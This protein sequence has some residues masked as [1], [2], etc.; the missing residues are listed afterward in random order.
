[1]TR[2]ALVDLDAIRSNLAV[3]STATAATP[4]M[5][6][7]KANAY[8]HGAVPVARAVVEA[9]AAWLGTAD[10]AE[11]LELRAAGVTAPILAWLH[12]PD[13]DFAPAIEGGVD[14]G[15]SYPR[16]LERVAAASWRSCSWRSSTPVWAVTERIPAR[17]LELVEAAAAHQRAGRL[18][19]RGVWSHLANAGPDADAGRQIATFTEAL[20]W[21]SAPP[22]SSPNSCTWLR[23]RERCACRRPGSGWCVSGSACT[24]CRRMTPRCP[25]S[26]PR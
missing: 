9:G 7:V 26:C 10:L 12:E 17:W 13:V 1:M 6:I 4:A 21:A 11:A 8:G 5:V 14:I 20:Q 16:R 15:V 2:E 3:L 25:G 22:G 19:V 24:D 23:R 18:V